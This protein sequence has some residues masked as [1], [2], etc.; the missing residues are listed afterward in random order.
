L[1]PA[2]LNPEFVLCS[3]ERIDRWHERGYAVNVWTVDGEGPIRACR[4]MQ[5]DGVIT[6]DPARTR[7]ILGR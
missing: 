1:R 4:E 6:N 2:A 3:R 7:E 5:V